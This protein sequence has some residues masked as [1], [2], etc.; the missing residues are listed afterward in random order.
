MRAIPLCYVTLWCI[1]L[2]SKTQQY[3]NDRRISILTVA[4]CFSAMQPLSGRTKTQSRYKSA[5]CMGSHIHVCI[6]TFSNTN[7]LFSILHIY[8]IFLIFMIFYQ[9]I[10]LTCIANYNRLRWSRGSVLAF[11]TQV[12]GFKPGRNRRI[13]KGERNPQHA[14]LRRGCKA[15][16]PMS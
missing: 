7:H 10:I 8:D 11:G 16:G 13:F 3:I 2:P 12:R 4:T 5:H 15:V 9:Y 14:F 6:K 1:L